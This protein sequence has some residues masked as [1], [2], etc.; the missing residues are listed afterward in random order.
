MGTIEYTDGNFIKKLNIV[1]IL[2]ETLQSDGSDFDSTLSDRNDTMICVLE[3]IK[4]D[5]NMICLNTLHRY[6]TSDFIDASSKD[7]IIIDYHQEISKKLLFQIEDYLKDKDRKVYNAPFDVRLAKN[8]GDSVNKID[9]IVQPDL[10]I[11]C[12]K[13][14]LDDAGCTGAPD[15]IIEILSPFT[16][17]KDL[18]DKYM[19][20]QESGIKE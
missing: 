4:N 3:S 17:V 14:K 12:D 13:S 19:L 6:F 11:V 15:W 5:Y 16:A 9:T 8:K 1:T 7:K 2:L 20:Y 18:N 10:L